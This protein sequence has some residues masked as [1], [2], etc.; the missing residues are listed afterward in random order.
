MKFS[1]IFGY[2]GVLLGFFFGAYNI[3]IAWFLVNPILVFTFLGFIVFPTGGLLAINLDSKDTNMAS[4][5]FLISSLG[6]IITGAQFGIISSILFLIAA[7]LEF[8]D[9]NKVSTINSDQKKKWIIIHLITVFL[10]P[11]LYYIRSLFVLYP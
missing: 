11:I 6:I 7:L 2:I 4:T 10:I 3:L 5:L 8:S 9:K 1:L